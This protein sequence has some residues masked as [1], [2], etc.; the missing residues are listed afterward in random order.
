MTVEIT[1]GK[2]EGNTLT[3]TIERQFRGNAM[4]ISYTATIEGECMEGTATNP[5]GESA[6]T[7]VRTE[8]WTRPRRAKTP[9]G[10]SDLGAFLVVPRAGA[11]WGATG[12]P[13]AYPPRVRKFARSVLP[14][15]LKS[16]SGWNC[17]PQSG[18]SRW[19]IA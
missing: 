18:S 10:L 4:V 1:N 7:A 8:G 15:S 11:G 19:R 16:D 6:F 13:P 17:T 2:I 9:P 14:C 3:F 12:W 5:R